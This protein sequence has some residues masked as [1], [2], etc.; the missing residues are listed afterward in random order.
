[1]FQRLL[2]RAREVVRQEQRERPAHARRNPQTQSAR[3]CLPRTRSMFRVEKSLSILAFLFDDF[4][5]FGYDLHRGHTIF[6]FHLRAQHI[7]AR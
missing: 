2:H 7:D 6:D 5:D 3:G 1:M 4:V